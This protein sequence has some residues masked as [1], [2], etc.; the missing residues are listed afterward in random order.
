MNVIIFGATGMVGRGALL[1]CL[2]D[3]RVERVLVISRRAVELQHSKLREILHDDFFDFARVQ[4]EFAGFDACFFC[5]GVSSIGMSERDYH[6]LTYDLTLAAAH[7]LVAT[8]GSRL[9][10]IYVT[11][12]GTDSTERGR[13]A[14][15]RIK[16]KT[17]NAL[18]RLPFK[19]AYMFRPGYIQPL[20]GIRSKTRWVQAVYDVVGALYP[21]LRRVVPGSVTTTENIGRAMI[22]VAVN[23]YS[24]P[25][26]DPSAMNQL[27]SR[28]TQTP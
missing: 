1:E 18:M 3:P 10:F 16:G 28:A 2:D 14:W 27:T 22:E 15:A 24:K 9:T 8:A 21:L 11:G 5:L 17:E 7:A 19:A 4:S 6:R 20:R 25:I 23:G 12:A 13:V 26:L